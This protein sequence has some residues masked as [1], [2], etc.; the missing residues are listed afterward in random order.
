[1]A[2]VYYKAFCQTEVDEE[3]GIRVT[4]GANH[5]VLRFYVSVYDTTVVDFL[6]S[7]YHLIRYHQD[8]RKRKTTS[9]ILHL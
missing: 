9:I 4:D 2:A 8:C 7:G 3:E 6:Q 1:M 5:D